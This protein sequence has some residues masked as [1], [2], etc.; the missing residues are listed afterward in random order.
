[1]EDYQTLPSSSL[2]DFSDMCPGEHG[3]LHSES[4]S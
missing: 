4:A 3:P 1:M 2:C